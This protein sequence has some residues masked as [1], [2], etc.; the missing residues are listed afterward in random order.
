M[1]SRRRCARDSRSTSPITRSRRSTR[2]IP[3]EIPE[4]VSS[5]LRLCART[6][7]DESNGH[8]SMTV[9]DA[10]VRWPRLTVRSSC[11]TLNH[12]RAKAMDLD[13]LR[14]RFGLDATEDLHCGL[15]CP[16]TTR[17][18][19]KAPPPRLSRLS[20]GTNR[21]AVLAEVLTAGSGSWLP[22]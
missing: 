15:F 7:L 3:R 5:Y 14:R 4:I 10:T 21:D 12:A 19:H 1:L 13:T 6:R 8:R 9:S 11:A 17:V 20:V 18:G 2:S 16:S 22:E